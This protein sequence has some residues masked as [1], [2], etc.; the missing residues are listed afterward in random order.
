MSYMF[1]DEPAHTVIYDIESFLWVLGYLIIKFLGPGEAPR[2]IT[3]TLKKA[4]LMFM[5]NYD[6]QKQKKQILAYQSR[7]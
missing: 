5:G 7:V 3:L 4:L 1:D 6:L 2:E